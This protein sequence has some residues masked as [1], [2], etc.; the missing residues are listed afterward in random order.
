[1]P[2]HLIWLIFLL[3]LV[4]TA[5]I[6][7]LAKP[8]KSRPQLSGYIGIAA[9][10]SSLVLSIWALTSLLSSSTH[11]I[12]VP[13]LQWLAIGDWLSINF[14]IIM[15]SL[16]AVMVA[17]I[18]LVSL[19]VLIYSQG[20]M[21][22]D[23]SY[24]RYFAYIT[25]FTASMLGFVMMDNLFLAFAF[26]ELVGLCSYLLIGFWFHRPAAANAAKKAF[27]VNRI[28][29]IGFLAAILVL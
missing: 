3:P 2:E 11:E 26:W 4:A 10:A 19:M 9:V 17:V 23:P 28:A 20:Y 5:A 22:G 8:L 1:M 15:D 13:A 24:N 12:A 18:S 21:K 7:L 16:S 29:D 27:I 25:L 6:F 14:G